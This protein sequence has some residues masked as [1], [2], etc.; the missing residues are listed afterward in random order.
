MEKA[1]GFTL[2]EVVIATVILV[3]VSVSTLGL[4]VCSLST[5]DED[6]SR[7]IAQ[8]ELE[9]QMEQIYARDYL[10]I[11]TTFTNAGALRET[12]F[13]TIIGLAGTGTVYAQELAVDELL[14]IKVVVCYRQRNR[15]IGEDTN[16][17]GM[18]APA[19]DTNANGELDSPCQIET[20]VVNREL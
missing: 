20:V 18:L 4:F 14:R 3:T 11:K 10:D 15:I 6:R 1:S 19:E 13:P 2:I 7:T 17:D 8:Y 12:Q 16:L 9:R 5:T